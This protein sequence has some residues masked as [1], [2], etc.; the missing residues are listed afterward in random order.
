MTLQVAMV[1]NLD[2]ELLSLHRASVD[3]QVPIRKAAHTDIMDTGANQP[4]GAKPSG[5]TGS[6]YP[7]KKN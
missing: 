6:S 4:K 1:Q 2:R 5:G 3:L 7:S